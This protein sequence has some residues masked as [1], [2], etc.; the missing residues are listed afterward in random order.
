MQP[1]NIVSQLNAMKTQFWEEKKV[2]MFNFDPSKN[3]IYSLA[4]IEDIHAIYTKLIHGLDSI[5]AQK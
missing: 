5:M 3:K 4:S 2:F 1:M